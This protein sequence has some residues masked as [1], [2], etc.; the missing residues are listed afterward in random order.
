[1][2]KLGDRLRDRIWQKFHPLFGPDLKI[3]F[4]TTFPKGTV[5]NLDPL[6]REHGLVHDPP[7][8]KVVRIYEPA[9][10]SGSCCN[11][12]KAQILFVPVSQKGVRYRRLVF[13][14]KIGDDRQSCRWMIFGRHAEV[15]PFGF[16]SWNSKN[17]RYLALAYPGADGEFAPTF[18][19]IQDVN[20]GFV[21]LKLGAY[22]DEVQVLF[23]ADRV[24][25]NIVPEHL[26]LVTPEKSQEKILLTTT[27]ATATV[28]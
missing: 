10:V 5:L 21:Y 9:R 12:E 3:G 15:T 13:A 16:D 24:D 6:Y 23:S 14:R 27:L 2:K 1:M 4:E 19:K 11:S 18:V 7:K 22:D 17:Q 8:E 26:R 28:R 25:E 20:R